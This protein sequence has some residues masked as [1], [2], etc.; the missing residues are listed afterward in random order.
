MMGLAPSTALWAALQ[1]RSVAITLTVTTVA[2]ATPT[3]TGP[4][5]MSL[6]TNYK[7][8]KQHELCC[9]FNPETVLTAELLHLSKTVIKCQSKESAG[10]QW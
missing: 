8:H 7:Q 4:K 1:M 5:H 9:E 6:P 10:N 2:G 3:W